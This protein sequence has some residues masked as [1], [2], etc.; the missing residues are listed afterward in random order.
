LADSIT[1][2]PF[3][4][5]H[6]HAIYFEYFGMRSNRRYPIDL[7]DMDDC[8]YSIE[9]NA[10][11]NISK[12]P[13][14]TEKCSLAFFNDIVTRKVDF[15]KVHPEFFRFDYETFLEKAFD[16]VDAGLNVHIVN[17]N[18]NPE[19]SIKSFL[20]Y[21]TRNPTWYSHLNSDQVTDYFYETYEFLY[22][23]SHFKNVIN[24]DY[25]DIMDNYSSTLNQ[26]F[27]TIFGKEV[28]FCILNNIVIDKAKNETKRSQ[29]AQNNNTFFGKREG[30]YFES[31]DKQFEVLKEKHS[32]KL[33]K[34]WEYYEYK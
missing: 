3:I 11:K 29:R 31:I 17:L 22:R 13:D 26:I 27:D 21:Q 20:N 10:S 28:H 16:L 19:D 14:F 24:V 5:Y 18:R 15:E 2:H 7:S 8:T 33:N 12:I 6:P 4:N 23:L 9:I 1:C 25:S 30:T 34:C 32:E